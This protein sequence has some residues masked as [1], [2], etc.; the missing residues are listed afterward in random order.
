M[1]MI[2]SQKHGG[3]QGSIVITAGFSTLGDCPT[4]GSVQAFVKRIAVHCGWRCVRERGFYIPRE[5]GCIVLK[6]IYLFRDLI[7]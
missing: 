1:R 3:Y 7:Y 5:V 6:R 4:D 2:V